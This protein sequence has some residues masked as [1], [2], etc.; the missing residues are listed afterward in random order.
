MS[1]D[2]TFTANKYHHTLI[3]PFR[4]ELGNQYLCGYDM[5]H[6]VSSVY[7]KRNVHTVFAS[8][9]E[10]TENHAN[11]IDGY[12]RRVS[13]WGDDILAEHKK[14]NFNLA[15]YIGDD[16]QNTSYYLESLLPVE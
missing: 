5:E 2:H 1:Y 9:T 7:A 6:A 3:D 13:K 16:Y 14:G 10:W 11:Y 8:F 15:K 12:Q 4:S